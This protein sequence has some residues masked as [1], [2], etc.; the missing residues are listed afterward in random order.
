MGKREKA[1]RLLIQGKVQGVGFRAWVQQ[2]AIQLGLSGFTRNLSDGRV[3]VF[4]QGPKERLDELEKRC[5]VGPHYAD[6]H[7]V[8]REDAEGTILHQGFDIRCTRIG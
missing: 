4:A 8:Q 7:S 2:Q 5:A 6:V 1:L 3:E